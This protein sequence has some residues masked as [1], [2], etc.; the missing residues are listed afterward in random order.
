MA[1]HLR[2]TALLFVTTL[3]IAS[4][5]DK[6][7]E[8]AKNLASPSDKPAQSGAAEGQG[9]QQSA[10]SGS[11]TAGGAPTTAAGSS[12]AGSARTPL[13]A[14]HTRDLAATGPA[15]QSAGGRQAEPVSGTQ[16]S[17]SFVGASSASPEALRRPTTPT[18]PVRLS[19]GIALEQTGPEGPIML[20]SVTYRF[21]GELPNPE[22]QYALVIEQPRGS[23]VGRPYK[24]Q[25]E[26]TFQSI[27]EGV[28]TRDGPFT[29]Y[30]VEIT[31]EQSRRV[32][33][34][35]ISLR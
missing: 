33:S 10:R 11:T 21:V 12:H 22:S 24:L 17:P 7:A 6:A 35:K 26:G 13:P 18:F 28:R 30:L 16:R 23:A 2:T 14:G 29:A 20:F 5:C 31:G 3:V 32:V 19:Q 4:G 8:F 9:A 1:M 34:D 15:Q 25:S 27:A